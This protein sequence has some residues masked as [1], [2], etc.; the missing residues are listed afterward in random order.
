MMAARNCQS[1]ACPIFG[2]LRTNRKTKNKTTGASVFSA[3]Q[4]YTEIDFFTFAIFRRL[5]N[6]FGRNSY[7]FH[8]YVFFLVALFTPAVP[9]YGDGA[10]NTPSASEYACPY[11]YPNK[12]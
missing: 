3:E 2:E 7:E 6:V 10:K 5:K 1:V 9:L 4:K 12:E 8:F 11:T